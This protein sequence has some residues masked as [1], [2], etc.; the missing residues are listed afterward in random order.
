MSDNV[1]NKVNS[2]ARALA[3]AAKEVFAEKG[4]QKSSIKDI[5]RVAGIATGTFYLYFKNKEEFFKV[6]AEELYDELLEHIR[7]ERRKVDGRLEKLQVSM[8]TCVKLFIQERKLAKLLLIQ[9]PGASPLI[10]KQLSAL[11]DGLVELAVEDLDD[12]VS[13]GL[14]PPQDTHISALALVGGFHA[15]LLNW[16]ENESPFDLEK[17]IT[18]YFKY[19]IAGL[20]S[21]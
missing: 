20:K 17:A 6:L 4:F 16:L 1:D 19:S 18:G 7:S 14:I 5:T 21:K 10:H 12:A 11:Q 13:S 2:K 3:A 8:E 9:V 15:I